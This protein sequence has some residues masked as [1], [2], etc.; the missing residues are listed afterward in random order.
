MVDRSTGCTESS[1][2]ARS[3]VMWA[4]KCETTYLSP[5]VLNASDVVV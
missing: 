4:D 1:K 5:L 2:Q 3:Y